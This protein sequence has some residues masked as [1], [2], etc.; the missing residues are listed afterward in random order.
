MSSSKAAARDMWLSSVKNG[1]PTKNKGH[2]GKRSAAEYWTDT[3]RKTS[4]GISTE[5]G[6]NGMTNLKSTHGIAFS[7]TSHYLRQLAGLEKT[8][9]A[10]HTAKS[11]TRVPVYKEPEEYYDEIL[12]LKKQMMLIGSENSTLKSKLQRLEDENM[13]KAKE[14]EQL[15]DPSKGEELRKTL[16]DRKPDAATM[17]Q[18][19][20]QKMIKLQHQLREKE[21]AL[22]KVES[23]LK[24]TKTEEMKLQLE[25]FY[26]EVVRLS[27]LKSSSSNSRK[28]EVR[29]SPAKLMALQETV[30]RLNDQILTLTNENRTLKQ[31]QQALMEEKHALKETDKD[32][33]GMSKG[34]LISVISRLQKKVDRG[35]VETMSMTSDMSHRRKEKE[36][37]GK[38]TLQ[39]SV[40]QRL[41]QLDKRETE[42]LEDI[43]KQ[44]G[45]VKRMKD[46]RAH[47]RKKCEDRDKEI[48][49]LKKDLEE[50]HAELDSFYEKD[51][52][53]VTPRQPTP[54]RR[55]S[56]RKTSRSSSITSLEQEKEKLKRIE[57][58]RQQ[59]AAQHI[60]RQ[61]KQR[62]SQKEHE[63]EERRIRNFQETRAAR[64]IQGGWRE[65]RREAE[66]RDVGRLP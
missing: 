59:V 49:N 40:A 22:S 11:M 48:K 7:S 46:D 51:K 45:I 38:L 32:Y 5:S 30:L 23:D 64:R 27:Q 47:Y 10:E 36:V 15:L 53:T 13:K 18:G 61:W 33:G 41:D 29:E 63:E 50:V 39:G 4:V 52:T 56:V 44:R 60:Q 57:E 58:F 28:G 54:R 34:E 35:D 37:A 8:R 31:D 12:A 21:A 66:S 62:K 1:G 2:V 43:E 14:I 24:T 16:G 25:Q 17:I 65:H 42:L 55:S 26:R 3:L 19:L 9:K 6:A 20:K